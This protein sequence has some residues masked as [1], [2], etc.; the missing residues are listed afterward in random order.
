MLFTAGCNSEDRI[1]AL[2]KCTVLGT[3]SIVYA[4][5]N[6]VK[7]FHYF[8]PD[9]FSDSYEQTKEFDHVTSRNII[10]TYDIAIRK[11]KTDDEDTESLISSCQ[12]LADFSKA[13]VDQSYPR[14]MSHQSKHDVLS[15]AFFIEI[16]QIVKFDNKIGVFDENTKS[17]KQYV[18]EYR[19]TVQNYVTK[20]KD[21][22]PEELINSF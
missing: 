1:S 21:E 8:N 10:N 4:R 15:D 13:F 19:N 16:N 12:Q 3:E 18:E 5:A 7:L 11:L 2:K 20:Y 17:F 6:Y 22:L 9:K 14:A